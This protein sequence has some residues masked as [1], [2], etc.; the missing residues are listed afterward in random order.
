[1]LKVGPLVTN[2]VSSQ[3]ELAQA[4]GVADSSLSLMLSGK[5]KFPMPR[6]VQTVYHLRPPQQEV[7]KAFNIYLSRLDLP[8]DSVEL[9]LPGRLPEPATAPEPSAA[10]KIDSIIKAV[11][12]SDLDDSAKV[13]IYNIIVNNR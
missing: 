13:K 5:Q 4:L 8:Q 3:R 1:M 2:W 12:N 9:R 6:F 10:E 11:M 7:D